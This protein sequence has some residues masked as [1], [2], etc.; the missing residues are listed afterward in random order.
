MEENQNTIGCWWYLLK[1][2]KAHKYGLKNPVV[3]HEASILMVTQACWC[4]NP[5]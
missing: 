5:L 2:E 4:S 3:A 1:C